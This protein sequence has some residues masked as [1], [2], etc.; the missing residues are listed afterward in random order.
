MA[1][2]RDTAEQISGTRREAE[3]ARAQGDPV[4]QGARRRGVTEQTAS[5]GRREA[6][7]LRGDQAKRRKARERENARRQRLVA[8]Q[9][10][11]TA[12]LQAVSSGNVCARRITRARR[13][14][15]SGSRRI[16]ALLRAEGWRVTH[17]RGERRWRQEGRRVPRKPRRRGWA[18]DGSCTR[19]R[20]ARPHHVWSD[21]CVRERTHDGRPLRVRT[22]VDAHTRACR[23]IAGARHLRSDDVRARLTARFVRPAPPSS[24]RSDTGPEF[25]ATAVRSWLRRLGGTPRCIEPGSP[26]EN[27]A[28]EA[29]NGTRRD[30]GRTPEIFTTRTEAQVLSARWRRAYTQGR[31][32][33][34]R[35]SRPPAPDA[36]AIGLPHPTPWAVRRVPVLTSRVA[37]RSG[38]GQSR[39]HRHRSDRRV[40]GT[41]M[42]RGRGAVPC[43]SG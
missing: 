29:C 36:L 12:S 37:Q 25:T 6:G 14:G 27:G 21:A 40:P 15:R 30:A 38:A 33:S 41:R 4:A 20:A 9:A 23:S 34:A 43:V 11:D 16:T 31:P 28:G 17:K 8:D 10:L 18:T 39:P 42:G 5:R 13:F 3:G 32:H 24:L 22:R 1:R 26:W 7:G 2:K 19:R 35:G